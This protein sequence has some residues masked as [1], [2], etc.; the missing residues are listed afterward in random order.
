[1]KIEY[2]TINPST[3]RENDFNHHDRNVISQRWVIDFYS[4]NEWFEDDPE[5]EP[6]YKA[7]HH[8]YFTSYSR[9]DGQLDNLGAYTFLQEIL[10]TLKESAL[11]DCKG[12]FPNNISDYE[13]RDIIFYHEKG[14]RNFCEKY[15]LVCSYY[16]PHSGDFHKSLYIYYSSLKFIDFMSP[17]GCTT[18]SGLVENEE[19]YDRLAS[20]AIPLVQKLSE[21]CRF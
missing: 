14:F 16:G 2:I 12:R 19:E 21:S 1:M 5:N 4:E 9:L 13:T 7:N 8:L 6:M 17:L 3:Y 20:G 11:M 18:A 15:G 10:K